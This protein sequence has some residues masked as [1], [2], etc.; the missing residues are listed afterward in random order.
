VREH[1]LSLPTPPNPNAIEP[2]LSS[3][4]S[5][6]CAASKSIQVLIAWDLL[7]ARPPSTHSPHGRWP[8]RRRRAE[9]DCRTKDKEVLKEALKPHQEEEA[10]LGV[11]YYSA[12]TTIAA[13]IIKEATATRPGKTGNSSRGWH[14]S[15]YQEYHREVTQTKAKSQPSSG[16][17]SMAQR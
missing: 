16:N 12:P 10:Y 1:R 13:R 11:L 17:S 4:S 6:I 8:A 15:G 2:I 14:E 5:S 3:H 7:L 9:T